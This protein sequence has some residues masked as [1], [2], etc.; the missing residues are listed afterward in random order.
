MRVKFGK[1]FWWISLFS[2]FWGQTI[3]VWGVCLSFYKIVSSSDHWCSTDW[4][5]LFF[6]TS[7]ILLETFGDMQMDNFINLKKQKKTEKKVLDTGLW[8]LS[9]HPNYLGEILFWWGIYLFQAW[10]SPAYVVGGPIA[11]TC[12]FLFVSVDLME[13]RQIK[14]KGEEFLAYKRKVGSAI[15]L[16]PPSLNS[17]L[18]T[19]L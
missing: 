15:F 12:L 6:S 1:H 10:F 11:L 2:V 3:F 8:S 9:R 18:G 5:G 7:G 16:L 13:E 17:K 4:C 14:S 19:F